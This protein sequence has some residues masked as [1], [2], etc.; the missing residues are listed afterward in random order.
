MN[1][2]HAEKY[3]DKSKNLFQ[4]ILI[5]NAKK[6]PIKIA[7]ISEQDRV[8]VYV[9][10]LLKLTSE[11]EKIKDKQTDQKAQLEKEI[12]KLDDE[13]DEEVYKLYGITDKEKKIIEDSLK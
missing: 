10:K 11:Y 4:K 9:D 2:Y 1:F 7:S 5:Q 6:F 3:L 12:Q 13:I 8:I